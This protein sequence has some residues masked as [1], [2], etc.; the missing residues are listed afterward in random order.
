MTT[1]VTQN[2]AVPVA[3]VREHSISGGGA[4]LLHASEWGN[5]AGP[6]VVLIHGWS[7]SEL[8]W[9]GQVAS[10]LA[11]TCRIVT[12]DLR[13]HG[14]SAKPSADG[15]AYADGRLWADD[16]AGLIDQAQ[17]TRPVLVAWSYGGF[18]VGDY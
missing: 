1:E 8:C 14:R 17:L 2:R 10:Q 15:D 6:A 16:L 4:T 12:F 5:S 18:V 13:G 3:A 9:S 7:Q 11:A